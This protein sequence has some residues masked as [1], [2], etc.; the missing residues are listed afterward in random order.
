MDFGK[1]HELNIGSQLI[2]ICIRKMRDILKSDLIKLS[3]NT[4]DFRSIP[5][6]KIV[7][8]WELVTYGRHLM[9]FGIEYEQTTGVFRL[10]FFNW[11]WCWLGVLVWCQC[12]VCRRLTPKPFELDV[13]E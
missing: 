4:I 11:F 1:P 7:L 3:H 8:I 5:L 6:F 13:F 12:L 2:P 10:V 9:E